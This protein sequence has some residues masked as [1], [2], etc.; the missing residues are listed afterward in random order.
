MTNQEA[1]EYLKSTELYDKNENFFYEKRMLDTDKTIFI[2]DLVKRFIEI[3]KK[4][5]GRPWNIMQILTNIN[6]IIP[7][8]DR[9]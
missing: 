3:D 6:M 4:F 2:E 5:N 9:E 8:E 1:I 7:I